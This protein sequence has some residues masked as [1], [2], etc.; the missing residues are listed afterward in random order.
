MRSALQIG[1]RAG[2]K[3]Y[4]N[5]AVL[6]VDRK[7][8]IEL[9][10]EAT[11]LLGSH[12]MQIEAA[13]TPLRQ[14]YFLVQGL[15]MDPG[16]ANTLKPAIQSAILAALDAHRRGVVSEGLAKV[17]ELVKDGSSFEALKVLR[18]LIPHENAA[19]GGSESAGHGEHRKEVA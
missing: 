8:R 12:V 9:L 1:L 11:F 18:T 2:E 13:T 5:G 17:G 19:T 10:N 4:I 7:V 6:S 16:V 3:I 15:L 14:I